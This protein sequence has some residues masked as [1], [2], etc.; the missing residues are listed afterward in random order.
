MVYSSIINVIGLLCFV[1]RLM[2]LSLQFVLFVFGLRWSARAIR[3]YA[4]AELEVRKIKY[5]KVGTESLLM[6]ILIEGLLQSLIG[7]FYFR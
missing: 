6:G 5:P 4:M 2:T 3:S 1:V 7:F